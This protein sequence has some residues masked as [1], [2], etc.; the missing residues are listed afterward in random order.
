VPLL[1]SV[2]FVTVAV[3]LSLVRAR[4]ALRDAAG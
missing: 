2:V 4:S 3:M 1:V